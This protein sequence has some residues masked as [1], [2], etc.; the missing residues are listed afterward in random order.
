VADE[1]KL[2]PASPEWRTATTLSTELIAGWLELDV[3]KKPARTT[4]LLNEALIG[5]T[6]REIFALTYALTEIAS[7]GLTQ[8]VESDPTASFATPMDLLRAIEAT[9][10]EDSDLEG[11]AQQLTD[12]P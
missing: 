10:N 12:D 3:E 4:E 1:N 8:F 7:S 5:R 11:L 2:T 6:E 9:R